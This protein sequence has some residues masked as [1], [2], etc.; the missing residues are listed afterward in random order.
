MRHRVYG[1]HLGRDKNQ[2][3]AL[4]RSLVGNLILHE[5][6]ETTQT[7]ASAIKGLVD[8]LIVKSKQDSQSS[9]RVV[10]SFLPQASLVKK[11]T[12]EIAPRY[13]DRNSGFTTIVKLGKRLGDGAMV[14]RM[15]LIEE[16]KQKTED[17]KQDVILASETS[18]ESK[19][20]SGQALP[21]GR[22]AGMTEE[23]PKRAPRARKGAK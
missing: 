19:E 1:K 6:I 11:L 4:F 7:K 10:N 5:S 2:R 18:P 16:S 21:A 20:D 22:Q 15:S 23:K 13:S 14:V 12:E 3:T 8:T 9:K 17:R